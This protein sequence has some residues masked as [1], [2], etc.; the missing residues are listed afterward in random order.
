MYICTH[1]IKKLMPD[2]KRKIFSSYYD[3]L[4]I[5]PDASTRDIRRA[6]HRLAGLYHP[7]R[8]PA[9][10]KTVMDNRL[11]V[12][13]AAYE[14]LKTPRKRKRYNDSLRKSGGNAWEQTISS[15]HAVNDSE[16]E[17]KPFPWGALASVGWPN[18]G[19]F[20]L[21]SGRREKDGHG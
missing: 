13:N 3:V 16:K 14:A 10:K 5:S 8:H 12:L 18:L 17:I 9:D 4:Q 11:Q 2:K 19:R 1:V 20:L 6:Y 21:I 15:M 7:D